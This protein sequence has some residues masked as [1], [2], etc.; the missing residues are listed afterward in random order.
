MIVKRGKF[1]SSP[2]MFWRSSI[3]GTHFF[4]KYLNIITV[5]CTW[6]TW[7]GKNKLKSDSWCWKRHSLSFWHASFH[8][9]FLSYLLQ[10]CALC[11]RCHL[12]GGM[13]SESLIWICLFKYFFLNIQMLQIYCIHCQHWLLLLTEHPKFSNLSHS[14]FLIWV[15]NCA[16]IFKILFSESYLYPENRAKR[17]KNFCGFVSYDR[18]F[19]VVY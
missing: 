19:W 15:C 18:G 9:Y 17:L 1:S 5:S 3:W 13:G 14:S 2:A 12:W 11:T 7:R 4:C 6:P 16:K 8:F 10:L